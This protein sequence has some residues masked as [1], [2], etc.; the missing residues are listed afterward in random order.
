MTVRTETW[1]VGRSQARRRAA[2]FV[3]LAK[4]RMVL[5]ILITTLVGFYLG[6]WSGPDY[7]RLLAT[8]LGTALAA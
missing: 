6:S 7:G 8:L 2:D 3:A 4:P 1:E 5:M